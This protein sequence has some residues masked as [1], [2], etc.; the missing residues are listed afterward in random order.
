MTC[1]LYKMPN[2]TTMICCSRGY[3][4]KRCR[5]C[6]RPATKL[7][8][9]QLTGPKAGQTC[10]TPL[11]DRCAVSLGVNMD[12][13]PVHARLVAGRPGTTRNNPEQPGTAGEWEARQDSMRRRIE[14]S[15]SGRG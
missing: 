8:D 14:R 11:C 12:Y 10:D 9:Y 15:R 4:T 3:N 5:V 2:G 1:R 13:C 6:G 7:C